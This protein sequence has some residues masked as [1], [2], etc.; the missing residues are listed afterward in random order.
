M[1]KRALARASQSERSE[2]F[3][4]SYEYSTLGSVAA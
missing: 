1:G 4:D 2:R 3:P